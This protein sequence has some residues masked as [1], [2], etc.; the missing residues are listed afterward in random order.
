MRTTLSIDS[1]VLSAARDLAKAER[2]TVGAVISD[3]ARRGLTGV[4][5]WTP[6]GGAGAEESDIDGWLCA[7]GFILL[8]GGDSIVTDGHVEALRDELGI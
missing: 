4:P 2:R 6:S 8:P 3:M 1:D 7:R 5:A